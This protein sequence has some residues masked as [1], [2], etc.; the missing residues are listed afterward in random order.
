[1]DVQGEFAPF[2]FMLGLSMDFKTQE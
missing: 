2:A 1:L